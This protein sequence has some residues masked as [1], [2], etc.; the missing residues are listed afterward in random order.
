MFPGSVIR[1]LSRSEEVFAQY[2]VFTAVTVQLRGRVDADA[3]SEAFDALVDA[4]PILASHLEHS[5]DGDWN[6]V[7]DDMLHA[8]IV[9]QE[10]ADNAC[11][12]TLDQTQTLLNLR[13]TLHENSSELTIFLHHSIADGHHG[14]GLFDELFSRYTDVVTTGDPGPVNPQPAPQ[15]LEVVLEQRGV[16]KLGMTGVERFLPVMF[17]YDLP[18]AVKPTLVATPGLPQPVPVTRVRL[19]EQETADLVEFAHENRVS[20]NTVVAAAILMTEW[21]LRETPHVPIPYVYPVDLRYFLSPPVAPTEAT[22]LVGVATYLAEVGP[23]T[24]IVDLATDIGV[25]FRSDI[26]DG[27]IQQSGLN[28][29]VAFEGTPA[30]LPPLVFCTDVSALPSVRMPAGIELEGFR[31]QFYCSITVPLDFYGCGMSGDHLVIENHGHSPQR[32]DSLEAIRE[33]LCTAPS[34]YGWAVE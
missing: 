7:S 8:G 23:D 25:T 12:I 31:G 2:E 28:F 15:P 22:N 29:G 18:P 5:P 4:H 26:A 13:L 19:S 21:R 27:I 6:L 33:L 30:G 11:E 3:L 1:K 16:K 17:A 34:D 10:G 32:K 20:V 14:A 9:V 24:D